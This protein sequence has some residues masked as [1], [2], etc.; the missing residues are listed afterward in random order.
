MTES[1]GLVDD[2]FE[3]PKWTNTW[4]RIP[5]KSV[6]G[7]ADVVGADYEEEINDPG[8]YPFT[9]GIFPEMYRGRLWTRREVS[10]HSSASAS[11]RRL[12][13]LMEQGVSG[14]NIIGD[15]PTQLVID[16]D[17][18]FAV[19]E[20][21]IQG[22]PLATVDDMMIL[23][24][25]IPM[26]EVSFTFSA[27]TPVMAFYVAAGKKR[28]IGPEKLRG[29]IIND[30]IHYR[31]CYGYNFP[32]DLGVR[33]A[34][35]SIG[36]S[37]NNMPLWYP[38]SVECY[39]LRE[40]GIDAVQELAF[41]FAI[42]FCLID[43]C[44]KKGCKVDDIASKITFTMGVHID[45]FEEAAKFRAARRLWAKIL[46]ERYGATSPKALH[47]K[48]HANT[49]GCQT[50]R[51]QPLNNI[52]RI[53]YSALAAV[54]GGTQSMQTVAFDEPIA[55]PTEESA[56]IAVRTQQIL[57]YETGVSRVADPL[58]GSYYIESLTNE[59]EQ[60]TRGL[61]GRI[62]DVGGILKA[63][64]S[65]WLDNELAEAAYNYQK[66]VENGERTIVGRNAF[67]IPEKEEPKTKVHRRV[68]RSVKKHMANFAK[69]KGKRDRKKLRNAMDKLYES[70]EDRDK[71]LMPEMVEAALAYATIGE[72]MGTIRQAYGYDY[73]PFGSV[74][75]PFEGMG[76]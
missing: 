45:I 5:V 61:L 18:P 7:R 65:Q 72:I 39:D 12:K 9:R 43:E 44:L 54:L 28:G 34:V 19:N 60:R 57:A 63:I 36:Y 16:S 66:E 48:F 42:A 4:S 21:G 41:G 26:K 50:V 37:I 70:A 23:T 25:G 13:Y 46:R 27:F 47:F 55:L 1:K 52:I 10:G 8:K 59:I 71:N 15:L 3:K 14:L 6:Y 56:R 40:H 22:T 76:R 20:V 67:V 29:T 30:T 17:H 75:S 64:E 32:L 58:G 38:F 11:N 73:D 35:D 31:Y 51:Q 74:D 49:S 33:L 2:Y 69:V 53:A 62:D 24:R 68:E